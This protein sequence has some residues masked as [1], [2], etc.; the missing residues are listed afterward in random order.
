MRSRLR[1][2]RAALGQQPIRL[3]SVEVGNHAAAAV[4][5]RNQQRGAT[6]VGID[7]EVRSLPEDTTEA[8]VVKVIQ[9]LN[10]RVEVAGIIVQRPL[11]PGIDPRTVQ[12]A[13]APQK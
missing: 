10:R 2:A 13:I 1:D 12:S 9:D 3:V 8:Q 4:Y 6:E 7:M 5:V 11:Q